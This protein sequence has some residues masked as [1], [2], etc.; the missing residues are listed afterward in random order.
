MGKEE[1]ERNLKR[2]NFTLAERSFFAR[3]PRV[4]AKALLGAKLLRTLKDGTIIGGVIVETEAYLAKGDLAAHSQRGRTAATRALFQQAGTIYIHSM[5]AYFGM[6]IVT[7]EPEKPSS[8]LIRALEPLEGIEEMKQLRNTEDLYSLTNG[9]GKLCQALCIDKDFYG[10]D[11]LDP[12]VPLKI[13]PISSLSKLS[14]ASS[15]RIGVNKSA[16]RN[17]RFFLKHNP[18]TSYF[19]S[20]KY[21]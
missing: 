8:V 21:R 2:N 17:L 1:F 7:E 13:L 12:L 6:D 20:R 9:P 19:N 15:K 10:V 5:R 18:F 11:L 14:M 4:V 3:N 16:H